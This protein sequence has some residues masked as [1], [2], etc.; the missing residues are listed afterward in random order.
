MFA[1]VVT[2]RPV[3]NAGSRFHAFTSPLQ[4]QLNPIQSSPLNCFRFA[5]WSHVFRFSDWKIPFVARATL[6]ANSLFDIVTLRV[7]NEKCELLLFGGKVIS[8]RVR[9]EVFT[10]VTMKN[11]VFWDVTPCGSCKNP[12]FGGT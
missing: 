4:D 9:F 7:S 12:R 6:T 1:N 10:A 5:K 2:K 8:E 11:G 3:M